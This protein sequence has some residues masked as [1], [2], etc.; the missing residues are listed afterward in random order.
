MKNVIK[1]AQLQHVL[2]QKITIYKYF[3]VTMRIRVLFNCGEVCLIFSFRLLWH[4]ILSL[5]SK[6]KHDPHKPLIGYFY[7]MPQDLDFNLHLTNSKYPIFVDIMLYRFMAETK[8]LK[9]I[10][11]LGGWPVVGA[12][13]IRYRRD[14]KHFDRFAVK[15]ELTYVSS[16]WFYLDY[17]FIKDG[18]IH[19][20]VIEKWGG[21]K[22]GTGMINPA[23][24]LDSG[25]G[26]VDFPKPPAHIAKM[27]A[28][29]DEMRIIVR[30]DPHK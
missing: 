20:H 3:Y 8:L 29:E 2:F 9:K 13:Y 27:M 14:L 21:T 5:L 15:V 1:G 26:V 25:P 11:E 28:T 24:L 7:V 22:K 19:A 23:E 30:K 10:R 12:R 6:V 4:F 17:K 18:F 16:R